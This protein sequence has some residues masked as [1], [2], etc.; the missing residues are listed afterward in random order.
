MTGVGYVPDVLRHL[1]TQLPV[2]HLERE[3]T[4]HVRPRTDPVSGQTLPGEVALKDW[5]K[6][7]LY[8]R[9]ASPSS[10]SLRAARRAP[11]SRGLASASQMSQR[12]R[13]V[14]LDN[15]KPRSR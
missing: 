15:Q 14:R 6:D 8:S 12:M 13:T 7:A 4:P 9:A 1:E 10:P 11:A 2:L 3:Y 5:E